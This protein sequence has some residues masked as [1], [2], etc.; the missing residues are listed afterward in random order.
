MYHIPCRAAMNS[1]EWNPEYTLLAYI[2]GMK[3]QIFPLMKVLMLYDTSLLAATY[4]LKI[5]F[6]KITMNSNSF[7]YIFAGVFRIFGFDSSDCDGGCSD[8]YL[9]RI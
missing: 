3:S 8:N 1:I 9:E 4:T 5:G 2:Q 6:R 7:I